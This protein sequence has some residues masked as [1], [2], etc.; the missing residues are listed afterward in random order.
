MMKLQSLQGATCVLG[1]L[2]RNDMCPCRDLLRG[3][4]P[5]PGSH[6][7]SQASTWNHPTS[8]GPALCCQ[9][10]RL[11]P[12]LCN[13][14]TLPGHAFEQ[15]ASAIDPAYHNRPLGHV[16]KSSAVPPDQPQFST[17]MHVGPALINDAMHLHQALFSAVVPLNRP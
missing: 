7:H 16:L 10:G 11:G 6:R 14:T 17:M 4:H 15:H 8:P 1:L 13:S 12:S 3:F 2:L 9:T 5:E